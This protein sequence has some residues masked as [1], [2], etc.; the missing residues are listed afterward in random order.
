M[1]GFGLFWLSQAQHLVGEFL[2]YPGDQVGCFIRSHSIEDAGGTIGANIVKDVALES[3]ID[4]FKS[5][6]SSFVIQALKYSRPLAWREL[7]YNI[8]D[9]RRAKLCELPTLGAHWTSGQRAF[10]QAL[11]RCLDRLGNLGDFTRLGLL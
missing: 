1:H 6:G 2:R 9:V 11:T 4:F 8:G 7:M 10:R 5:S 3:G